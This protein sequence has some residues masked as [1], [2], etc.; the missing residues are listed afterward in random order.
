M[1]VS[2]CLARDARC[3]FIHLSYSDELATD[4]SARIK[5]LI[6]TDWYQALWGVQF[7]KSANQKALWRTE[8]GG[9]IKAGPA[10]G[11]V[12][13]FGAGVA[14]DIPEGGSPEDV[15][16]G[17]A[18]LA[19]DPIK[20]DDAES[21]V[22]RKKINRRL[23]STIKSRKNAPW[24]PII[25]IMQR[26][27]DDDPTGF[28]MSGG[29]GDDWTLLKIPALRED[30]TPLWTFRHT[31]DDLQRI[32]AA[33]KYVWNGQYMQE[34]VPDEG[35]FFTLDKVRWYNRLPD[36][37]NYYGASDYAASDASGADFTEH[38]I[39][40]VCPDG[41]IYVV[42]WWSG[43]TKSDVWVE[44][45]LDLVAKYKPYL[46]GG[47]TGPIKAAVE[48]WLTKRM[49]ERKAYVALRWVN[50]STTNYKVA[51]ARSFQGMWE[52]GRVYF[53]SAEGWAQ[54]VIRQLTRFPLGTL[55]DKVDCCSIF[56]RMIMQV[57]EKSP[58][59]PPEP[60]PTIEDQPLILENFRSKP[61]TDEW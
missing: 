28:V 43:Q 39:F 24:T 10:G 27:H 23:N 14:Y 56:A 35:D 40:G 57:W 48:P 19:D 11:A 13:G 53:P 4:N 15:P 50:H 54:D 21:D 29:T 45:Q 49:R 26:V 17:G 42:D 1:F 3:Q 25:M 59:K 32:M 12:T 51:N 41:N 36:H 16:F 7:K 8:A 52:A 47:E 34:P 30:G 60:I 55:D 38:A 2:W 6:E 20:P 46:W 58:P 33:D 61:R 18:I 31:L 37:L 22:E 9:G 44:E 5:D